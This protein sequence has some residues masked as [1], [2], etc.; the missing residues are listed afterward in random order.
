MGGISF[1]RAAD[2]Y[3]ATRRLPDDVDHLVTDLL[4]RELAGKGLTLEIGVGT[5]RIALPLAQ[6]GIDLIGADLSH[7]M[8]ARLAANAG[9]A[10]LAIAVADATRLP[11]TDSSV[12]A[13]LA[14]HVLHLVPD[15]RAALDEVCRVVQPGGELLLDFGGPT[16]K[17]WSDGCDEILRQHGVFRTRPGV[18]DPEPVAGYLGGRARM[19]ALPAIHFD[20]ETSLGE[21][22]DEW[23]RQILA[24]TWPYPA[25][26]IAAACRAIRAAAGSRGW[27]VDEQVRARA[28]VQ[29]W[30][31]D[32]LR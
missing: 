8:L 15:W 4:F 30:A 10:S 5:G 13:V 11:L 26:Q 7:A 29:W 1:D 18:F 9:E 23:E 27:A 22:L 19:R 31:F 16:A 28:V 17:P 12:G 24:W 3:D 14:C 6:R 32:L 20:V 2:Y 21:D 25:A